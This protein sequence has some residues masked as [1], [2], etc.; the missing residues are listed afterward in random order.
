MNLLN[1]CKTLVL[2]YLVVVLLTACTNPPTLYLAGD[3]TMANKKENR[4]P[5]T[6][7]GEVLPTFFQ[8]NFAIENHAKNGRSTRSFIYE[9]RWDSLI[10]KVSKGDFVIIQFGHNDDV[11]TKI[12]RHST[13]EEYKY[14]LTRFV[15]DVKAK[16]AT[17]ILCT[18]VQRRQFDSLGV[19]TNT[20]GEYP[21]VVKEVAKENQIALID[22]Q[23]ISD[24]VITSLG[25]VESAK[26]FMRLQPGEYP[27]YP[28]G[29]ADDTH[30]Q[31]DGATTMAGLFVKAIKEK[32]LPLSTYLK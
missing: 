21:Q 11:V 31:T 27:N 15:T 16:K 20:H 29:R 7:W 10:A 30:F 18:P 24:S 17:P 19:L 6:G 4:K 8:D 13:L 3:S 12:G 23:Q 14:N 22:M 25:K 9:G 5:E 1:K 32:S 26:L 28:K 2:V